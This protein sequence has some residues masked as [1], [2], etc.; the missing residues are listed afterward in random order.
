MRVASVTE[1]YNSTSRLRYIWATAAVYSLFLFLFYPI[2]L[3]VYTLCTIQTLRL[4]R[5]MQWMNRGM[6]GEKRVG[7]AIRKLDGVL[8]TDV[9]CEINGK[10]FELDH[11][12]VGSTG[13]YAIE[14]K[15]YRGTLVADPSADHWVQ[16]KSTSNSHEVVN[17]FINPLPLLKSKSSRLREELDQKVDMARHKTFVKPIVVVLAQ[18]VKANRKPVLKLEELDESLELGKKRLNEEDQIAICSAISKVIV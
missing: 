11:I 2:M 9:V 6:D 16:V 15:T 8:Y 1:R 18:D 4:W 13:I 10:R 5:Y 17:R 12:Y 7:E 14:V 3:L